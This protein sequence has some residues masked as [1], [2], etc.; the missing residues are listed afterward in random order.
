MPAA[1]ASSA[2]DHAR[3]QKSGRPGRCLNPFLRIAAPGVMI[4]LL[5]ALSRSLSSAMAVTRPSTSGVVNARFVQTV[6]VPANR[7]RW[8]AEMINL[9]GRIKPPLLITACRIGASNAGS[10]KT[11]A[12]LAPF[13]SRPVL[14]AARCPLLPRRN[15]LAVA[16]VSPLARSTPFRLPLSRPRPRRA[17][18]GQRKRQTLLVTFNLE[19]AIGRTRSSGGLH[20]RWQTPCLWRFSGGD[21]W[22]TA[23]FRFNACPRPKP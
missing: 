21:K 4:A 22:A 2:V 5:P 19:T 16:P 12:T 17:P 8:S 6:S 13:G 3:R 1:A 11:F 15:A 10:A 20:Q 7:W 23:V 9:A 14:A 18:P